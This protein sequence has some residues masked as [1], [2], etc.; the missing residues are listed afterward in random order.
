MA[1]AIKQSRIDYVFSVLQAGVPFSEERHGKFLLKEERALLVLKLSQELPH[2]KLPAL[3]ESQNNLLPLDAKKGSAGSS[4]DS[5]NLHGSLEERRTSLVKADVAQASGVA[6][7]AASPAQASNQG[8]SPRSERT[9]AEEN[10]GTEVKQSK[11]D[12]ALLK[13]A[14]AAGSAIQISDAAAASAVISATASSTQADQIVQL[15]AGLQKEQSQGYLA[16]GLEKLTS[17]LRLNIWFSSG[18]HVVA[19][20]AVAPYPVSLASGAAA[21]SSLTEPS[22]AGGGSSEKQK[23]NEVNTDG[24]PVYPETDGTPVDPKADG[25]LVEEGEYVSVGAPGGPP[26]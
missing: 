13:S 25:V 3:P 1:A 8:G 2:I 16:W 11:E 22:A 6:A 12:E 7:A 24:T 14:S 21:A 5:E 4:A 10:S 23:G 15:R 19:G 20:A 26:K 9:V 18:A 17:G